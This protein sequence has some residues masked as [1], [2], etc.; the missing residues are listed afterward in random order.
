MEVERNRRNWKMLY[1]NEFMKMGLTRDYAM[2]YAKA[3]VKCLEAYE[4]YLAEG[5]AKW[6][7]AG[8][9]SVMG[10]NKQNDF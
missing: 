2:K 9:I 7:P 3:N 6:E 1:C 8:L 4:K 10:E 5:N